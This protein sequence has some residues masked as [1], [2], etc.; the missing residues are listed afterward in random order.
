MKIT[1]IVLWVAALVL[2]VIMLIVVFYP[3][4]SYKLTVNKRPVASS[5]PPSS[6][7][8]STPSSTS[9]SQ[10]TGTAPL[11][12]GTFA[13][14][15]AFPYSVV[16]TESRATLSLTGASF[17]GN[18]ITFKLAIKTGRTYECIQMNL[19]LV[20]DEL[21]NLETP[22]TQ[23]FMF[24]DSGGC[25]STPNKSYPDQAVVFTI[26]PGVPSP[27]LFTTGGASDVFF[28][29]ATTSANGIEITLPSQ[30]G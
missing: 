4:G 6:L 11:P 13:S 17:Q 28:Q 26:D 30:S 15:Y 20:S 21:G 14:E 1:L 23:Q 2:G 5:S 10:T 8:T 12:P 29:V 3:T 7:P 22:D 16:W 9:A 27:F 24:P 25:G 19:R 18:K